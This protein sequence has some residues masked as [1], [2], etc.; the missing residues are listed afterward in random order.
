MNILDRARAYSFSLWARGLGWG[1]LGA[2]EGVW[3]KLGNFGRFRGVTLS[4]GR[5]DLWYRGDGHWGTVL[6]FLASNRC[7]V[8]TMSVSWSLY[9]L[10]LPT[11][12]DRSTRLDARLSFLDAVV[13]FCLPDGSIC[14]VWTRSGFQWIFR[15]V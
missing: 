6:L 2:S 10:D 14:C 4:F 9:L 15:T 8:V 7:K 11:L 13:G 5:F 1:V 12:W 3:G